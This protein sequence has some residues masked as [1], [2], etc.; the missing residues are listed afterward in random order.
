[1]RRRQKVVAEATGFVIRRRRS[2]AMP[3]PHAL[4]EAPSTALLSSLFSIQRP[5]IP[6]TR[7]TLTNSFLGILWTC[8]PH[9][10]GVFNPEPHD[11]AY[12]LCCAFGAWKSMCSTVATR[13][14]RVNTKDT[15]QTQP[16][17]K[18]RLPSKKTMSSWVGFLFL[19]QSP[20]K[21][22]RPQQ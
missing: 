8:R 2:D 12:R 3:S 9:L 13:R 21:D 14:F 1:M 11:T 18:C 19:G 20:R 17:N 6:K 10:L 7:I 15:P 4:P 22:E 16:T 5:N